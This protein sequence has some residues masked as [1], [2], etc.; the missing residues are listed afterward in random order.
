MGPTDLDPDEA[1]GGVGRQ[2]VPREGVEFVTI[3]GGPIL[4]AH[5]GHAT[6]ALT[7]CK[8]CLGSLGATTSPWSLLEAPMAIGGAV[9]W[10]N[11]F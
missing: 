1:G 9:V 4:E 11:L 3:K 8:H 6:A 7:P 2:H 5:S 10:P